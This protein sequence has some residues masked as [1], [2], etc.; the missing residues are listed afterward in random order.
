MDWSILIVPGA[1]IGRAIFGW[2]ENAL[3]DGVIELPEWKKLGETLVRMGVPM[4]ALIWGL[5]VDEVA[6]AG[7]VTIL[8]I[9]IVKFYNAIKTKKVETVK[10]KKK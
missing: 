3:G 6:A 10:V 4:V 5:N 2:L 1:A 9:V 7:I 8:D